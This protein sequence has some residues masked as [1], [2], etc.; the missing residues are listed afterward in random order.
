MG[1]TQHGKPGRYQADTEKLMADLDAAFVI[2]IVR[3]GVYGNGMSVAV[4]ADRAPEMV[5]PQHSLV[6]ARHL[7]GL[8]DLIDGG[9][10]P[11][12]VHLKTKGD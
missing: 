4:R 8:A 12:G 3:D 1:D 2:L 10:M 5:G 7:R 6:V 9:A 11:G